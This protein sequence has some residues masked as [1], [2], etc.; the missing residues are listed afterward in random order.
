MS[1]MVPIYVKSYFDW[2][3]RW[4]LLFMWKSF[5]LA[6]LLMVTIYA[7]VILIGYIVDGY[8][9]CESH[10]DWLYCWWL[11]FM[12]KLF[13]LAILLMVTIY[14]KVILIGYIVDGY[15]LC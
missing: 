6:I 14:A 7:K 9:L 4:C 10:F 8:Y 11:L 5:W 2:V 12:L 13:W 3:C 15:Y 1:L